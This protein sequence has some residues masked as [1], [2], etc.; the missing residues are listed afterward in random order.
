[1][2]DWGAHHNDIALWGMGFERSGPVTIEGRR[3]VEPIAGGY[4]AP[5]EYQVDYTYQNGVT[6][7]CQSTTSNGP[8]GSARGTP[9]EGEMPH[10]VKF[11]GSDGWIFVTRGKIEASR[12][13]LLK[14][15]LTQKTVDLYV[16][17]NHMGNFFDCIRS[18][19]PPICDAEIG[20]RSVSVCHL[21]NIA[22]QLDRKLQWN[23]QTEQFHDDP[24]ANAFVARV[25]R[26]PFSYEMIAG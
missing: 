19:K 22:M 20:H 26:K 13:E 14:E 4:T 9:R 5:S 23:P 3:L 2:T 24:E 12:E 6:H 18:R 7:R 21:G 17:N 16:S 25:Q 8:D 11:I 15:P 1:M 10:G